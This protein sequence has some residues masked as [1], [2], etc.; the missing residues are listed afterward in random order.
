MSSV[1]DLLFNTVKSVRLLLYCNAPI[2][3]SCRI[4]RSGFCDVGLPVA[5]LPQ[6]HLRRHRQRH[7]LRPGGGAVGPG[8]APPEET[9]CVIAPQ[10]KPPSLSP[11]TAAL[12]AGDRGQRTSVLLSI[13]TL[14]LST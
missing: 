6:H 11:A 3:F 4:S 10:R 7:Y 8:A 9:E 13:S 2:I 12:P 1:T 14:Q 5:L